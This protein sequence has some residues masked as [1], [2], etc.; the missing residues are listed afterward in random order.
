MAVLADVHA[1]FPA[2][3]AVTEH[4]DAWQPDVVVGAGLSRIYPGPNETHTRPYGRILHGSVLGNRGR[5]DL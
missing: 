5:M 4:M 1:N 3:Q 2:L